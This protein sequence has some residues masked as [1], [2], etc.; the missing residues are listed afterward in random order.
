MIVMVRE[1]QKLF[2]IAR[3]I[4]DLNAL[5]SDSPR[6]PPSLQLVFL[7]PS[8]WAAQIVRAFL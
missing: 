6:T 1:I 8:T 3:K 7:I 2:E 5:R 4:V